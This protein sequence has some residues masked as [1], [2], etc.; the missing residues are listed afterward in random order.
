MQ[1][2]DSGTKCS[3]FDWEALYLK[4]ERLAQGL[5]SPESSLDSY[6]KA[7]ESSGN[8]EAQAVLIHMRM[9]RFL[10]YYKEKLGISKAEFNFKLRDL[11]AD[12]QVVDA[13]RTARERRL[14]AENILMDEELEIASF[15]DMVSKINAYRE[16]VDRVITLA[17]NH[18]SDLSKRIKIINVQTEI[19]EY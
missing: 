11:L 17:K 9:G 6:H 1:S 2:D 3:S 18:R 16:C 7:I 19:G 14:I 10:S 4:L 5:I 15:T 12:D 8:V 13:K